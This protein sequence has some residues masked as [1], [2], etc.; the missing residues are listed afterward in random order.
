MH[1]EINFMIEHTFKKN[2]STSLLELK[3]K[4][5]KMSKT[6][7]RLYI[8]SVCN[9]IIEGHSPVKNKDV[10]NDFKKKIKELKNNIDSKY[11]G[12]MKKKIMNITRYDECLL[13]KEVSDFLNNENVS[14]EKNLKTLVKLIDLKIKKLEVWQMLASNLYEIFENNEEIDD[15]I[16]YNFLQNI[17]EK[18]EVFE[19]SAIIFIIQMKV[20]EIC[21]KNSKK[22]KIRTDLSFFFDDFYIQ[23]FKIELLELLTN[24]EITFENRNAISN[25]NKIIDA[26][27]SD[28]FLKLLEFDIDHDGETGIDY[29]E[30][31]YEINKFLIRANLLLFRL[32]VEQLLISIPNTQYTSMHNKL[33]SAFSKK[34]FED[35]AE[36]YPE[37]YEIIES[38]SNQSDHS[39]KEK[40][41]TTKC[42]SNNFFFF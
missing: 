35:S 12:L 24:F 30:F 21:T 25:L 26:P 31:K 15:P 5:K 10:C 4:L 19:K 22:T 36:L 32:E 39:F 8:E 18:E 16:I 7:L 6:Y 28:F 1:S 41:I 38:N 40:V 23:L 17:I 20:L 29:D 14:I 27:N 2:E 42:F 34:S 9:S 3:S 13:K 11:G 33:I 37:L